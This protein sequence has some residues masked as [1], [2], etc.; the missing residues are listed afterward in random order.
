M[1]LWDDPEEWNKIQDN[2]KSEQFVIIGFHSDPNVYSIRPVNGGQLRK[3]NRQQLQDLRL[4]QTNNS[5]TPSQLDSMVTTKVLTFQPIQQPKATPHTHPYATRSKIKGT[6]L[7]VGNNSSCLIDERSENQ[8]QVD[9]QRP[10][11]TNKIKLAF[12]EKLKSS[13]DKVK[14]GIYFSR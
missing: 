12:S 13:F 6:S 14:I 9:T 10:A 2:F 7:L 1:L 4:H 8:S 3:V 11:L 5:G